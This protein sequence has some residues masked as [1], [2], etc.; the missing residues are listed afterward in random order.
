M[1][2]EE[3]KR[4]GEILVF[5]GKGV[6]GNEVRELGSFFLNLV[7]IPRNLIELVGRIA[8]KARLEIMDVDHVTE[9][10]DEHRDLFAIRGNRRRNDELVP[11]ELS[12]GLDALGV[13]GDGKRGDL[14][15]QRPGVDVGP[16]EFDHLVVH[17]D[18]VG[19]EGER[20]PR[21]HGLAFRNF[22]HGGLFD[23]NFLRRSAFFRFELVEREYFLRRSRGRNRF[24]VVYRRRIEIRL[25]PGR[26]RDLRDRRQNEE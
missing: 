22:D 21:R 1:E 5:V 17:D 23:R 15:T 12:S 4:F 13:D 14:F 6:A 2:D 18:G 7:R 26:K 9:F 20:N 10:V 16:Q 11:G 25:G 19:T 8:Q 3:R 24:A